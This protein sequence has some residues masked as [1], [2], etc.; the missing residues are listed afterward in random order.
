MNVSPTV[1][2][3][4]VAIGVPLLLL[5][6]GVL[7]HAYVLGRQQSGDFDDLGAHVEALATES[8]DA[9]LIDLRDAVEHMQGQLARQR[10]SLAGLLSEESR[11]ARSPIVPSAASMQP[12]M[13]PVMPVMQPAPRIAEPDLGTFEASPAYDRRPAAGSF[14]TNPRTTP[15]APAPGGSLTSAVAELVAEGLSDRAIARQLH[16]GL[17]EVRMA[18]MRVGR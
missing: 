10:E 12:A 3:L 1:L 15:A 5:A 4:S 8:T 7:Y 9:L 2:V 16:I 17:E 6:L 18:R 14:V 13:Q 11:A